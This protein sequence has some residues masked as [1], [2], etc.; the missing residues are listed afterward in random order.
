MSMIL[1]IGPISNDICVTR[2]HRE[3]MT[4]ERIVASKCGVTC[5]SPQH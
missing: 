4:E 1:R 5:L 3:Y 2:S